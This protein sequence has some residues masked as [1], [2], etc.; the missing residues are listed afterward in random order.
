MKNKLGL[1]WGRVRNYSVYVNS[2]KNL[3]Q[4]KEFAMKMLEILESDKLIINFNETV[5][6]STT[7]R[8]QSREKRGS[9]NS[10]LYAKKIDY[11]S[12][13]AAIST[14]GDIFF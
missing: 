14:R 2:S 1:R 9:S 12:L 4:R 10:R 7:G 11:L 13:M 8:N 6:S 5:I 3:I